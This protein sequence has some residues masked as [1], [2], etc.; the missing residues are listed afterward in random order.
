[1]H[2]MRTVRVVEPTD[3]LWKRVGACL[4][5]AAIWF[6]GVGL[7]ALVLP[8]WIGSIL[9]G[10]IAAALWL[11]MFVVLQGL[12]GAS[13]GKHLTGIR[14][15]THEGEVCGPARAA[16]RSV[17]W[18]V[19]GFPY[20]LPLT[21]YTAA[22]G[23]P[24]AQRF[25]DRWAGTYVIDR[26]YLGQSPEA[27]AFPA[28]GRAPYLLTTRAPY[29]EGSAVNPL[30]RPASALA[31]VEARQVAEARAA[32]GLAAGSA[33]GL[34]PAAAAGAPAP[35][36]ASLPGSPAQGPVLDPVTGAY[37]R[38]DAVHQTWAVFDEDAR[39]W[40]PAPITAPAAA[41]AA[42]GPAT[43]DELA[44]ALVRVTTPDAVPFGSR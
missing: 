14:V 37:T 33:G 29:L 20:V 23:D 19:D 1:M 13:P 27:V 17:A 21:G 34:A 44:D 2:P 8:G 39:Q 22:F 12:T 28:D 30:R 7:A 36:P 38:W 9:T 26:T 15:V 24:L 4:I 18:I 5:D 32:A 16:V 3:V 41:P 35:A 40:V 43:P 25:G 31:E 42:L 11:G 10:V 6:A